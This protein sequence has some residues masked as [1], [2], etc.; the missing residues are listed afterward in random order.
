MMRKTRGDLRGPGLQWTWPAGI[1]PLAGQ[2]DHALVSE[3]VHL[4]GL[5]TG[6]D[7]GSDHHPLVLDA[8]F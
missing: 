7:I 4:L 2:I 5:E 1:W 3:Q 6:L 8:E